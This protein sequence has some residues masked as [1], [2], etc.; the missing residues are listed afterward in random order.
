M[1]VNT[2]QSNNG[3]SDDARLDALLGKWSGI[4]P[5]PDFNA[6]VWRRM[7]AVTPAG[8]RMGSVFMWFRENV[9]PVDALMALG[10]LAA[11]LLLSLQVLDHDVSRADYRFQILHSSGIAGGYVQ[12]VA[13][14]VK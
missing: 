2:K 11:G 14:G 7:S 12:L 5:A 6:A 13:K 4:T 3:K 1:T 10:G 8:N 9:K